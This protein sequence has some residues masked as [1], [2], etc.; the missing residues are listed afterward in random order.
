MTKKKTTKLET[1][2]ANLTKAM[3]EGDPK[4]IATAAARIMIADPMSTNV[5]LYA[6]ALF[7]LLSRLIKDKS[8]EPYADHIVRPAVEAEI[9][10]IKGKVG[11]PLPSHY[12]EIVIKSFMHSLRKQWRENKALYES[13]K[14]KR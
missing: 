8:Y 10:K 11:K 4:K 7:P 3:E 2:K 12:R 6:F 14:K 9:E 13:K 1:A 5:F